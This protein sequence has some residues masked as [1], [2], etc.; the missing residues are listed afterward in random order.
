M[1]W[2][3]VHPASERN[4]HALAT[5]DAI[6]WPLELQIVPEARVDV[7]FFHGRRRPEDVL[8]ASEEPDG[9]I[10][11]YVHLA[12]HLPLAS[13]AHVVHLRALAVAP[14]ARGQGI[15][16]KLIA[17]GVDAARERG[18]LKVGVRA[19]ATNTVAIGLYERAG[20]VQEGR[21]E[22]EFRVS[23]GSYVDDLWFAL[24]L[25]ER[26]SDGQDEADEA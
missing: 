23:D 11:G 7:P 5:L 26:G 14:H 20:F 18:A 9:V 8:V 25:G 3:E 21:L 1:P 2:I 15:G 19:L 10:L 24:W 6:V 16:A 22:D 12:P 4:D 17:A 13:N